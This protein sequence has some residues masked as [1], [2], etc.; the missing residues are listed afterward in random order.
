[1]G[2]GSDRFHGSTN[3]QLLTANR[4]HLQPLNQVSSR[5]LTHARDFVIR[6]AE[7]VAACRDVLITRL[8][9]GH[10][11]GCTLERRDDLSIPDRIL[12]GR[13]QFTAVQYVTNFRRWKRFSVD[14][15]NQATAIDAVV[16]LKSLP[17]DRVAH[18]DRF[19]DD[20]IL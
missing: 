12:C 17:G 15:H 2:F 7:L 3:C 16:Q 20:Q 8:V 5:L 4:Q 10:G 13:T 18:T 19:I 11:E 9:D 14:T 1:M 6:V